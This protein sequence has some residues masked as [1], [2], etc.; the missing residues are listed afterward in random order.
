MSF[1]FSVGDFIAAAQLI[2]AIGTALS[3]AK[4]ASKDYR[5]LVQELKVMSKTFTWVKEMESQSPITRGIIGDLKE[6]VEDSTKDIDEFLKK[7]EHYRRSLGQQGGSKS[8]VM[9]VVRK[10]NWSFFKSKDVE[11]LRRSLQSKLLSVNVLVAA[12][13]FFNDY[14][15]PLRDFDPP[16]TQGEDKRLPYRYSDNVPS[17]EDTIKHEA[18]DILWD[19]KPQLKWNLFRKLTGK[20]G[21]G[22]RDQTYSQR[23]PAPAFSNV[24]WSYCLGKMITVRRFVVVREGMHNCFCLSIRTFNKSGCSRLSPEEQSN[25]AIIYTNSKP[26]SLLPGESNVTK[27]PIRIRADHPSTTLPTTA[28]V[29]FSRVY[30][31]KHDVWSKALGLVHE[32]C[33]E[34]LLD[35]FEHTQSV[36]A[37]KKF[38]DI[39]G[40][41]IRELDRAIVEEAKLRK[42]GFQTLE[43]MPVEA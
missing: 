22:I 11:H 17:R 26:P 24:A 7:N 19:E 35:Q 14:E 23:E 2:F 10:I 1:G 33:V 18:E 8:A 21:I 38:E 16:S 28:R 9:D 20:I 39:N 29:D 32:D 31:V 27:T 34:T 4:G 12:A 15:K 5:D 25:Y 30:Q 42:P 40:N 6:I 36:E 41:T 37:S 43:M 13:N 3:D